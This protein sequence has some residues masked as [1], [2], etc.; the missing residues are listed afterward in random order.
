MVPPDLN[1]SMLSMVS[2]N[3]LVT[4]KAKIVNLKKAENVTFDGGLDGTLKKVSAVLID[5]Y[6]SIKIVLWQDDCEKVKEGETYEFRNLRVKKNKFTQEVYVNPAKHDS[7]IIMCLPFE[8]V[9]AVPEHVPEEFI[10]SNVV[11]EVVGI[12]D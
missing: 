5:P 4:L 12:S 7:T 2:V 6:G 9:L 3:Q 10:T 1:L 8:E 11:G